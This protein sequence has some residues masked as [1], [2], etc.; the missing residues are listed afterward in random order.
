MHILLADHQP[1]AR[2][3]LR[4]L[5]ERRCGL[6]VVGEATNAADLLTLTHATRP[7]LLLLTWELPGLSQAES[8]PALRSLCPDL[9][10]IALSG[11]PELRQAALDAGANAFV[12]KCESPER[13]LEAIADCSH[14]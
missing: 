6:M 4:V 14:R 3:A 7:D 13:L 8:L 2:L 10:I 5:L 1:D 9:A 11:R 12:W